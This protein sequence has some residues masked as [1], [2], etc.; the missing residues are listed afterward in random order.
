[1]T[2]NVR[3]CAVQN[4]G[5]CVEREAMASLEVMYD[6]VLEAIQVRTHYSSLI[7]RFSSENAG[8]VVICLAC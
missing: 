7:P 3:G 6:G 5:R 2:H 4:Q 1:M 8:C